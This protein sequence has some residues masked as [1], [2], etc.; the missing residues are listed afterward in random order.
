MSMPQYNGATN[1]DD[2]LVTPW[3]IAG[4]TAQAISQDSVQVTQFIG[5]NAPFP[6][7]LVY[8][9][10]EAPYYDFDQNPLSGFLTFLTSEDFNVTSGGFTYRIPQRY[11]G[12]DNAYYAG[13]RNNRGTGKI[14]IRNGLVS[15]TL[16]ATQN[17][18]IVTDSGLPLTY[19]VVEHFLGGEQYDISISNSASSPV[20]LR[21]LIVPGSIVPF[22]YDPANPLGVAAYT[23]IT[24][25][26]AQGTSL[27]TGIDG[28]SA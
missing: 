18:A 5:Q 22:D 24:P 28:G 15:V 7:N 11:A 16:M 6:T 17:V 4:W 13:G 26:P 23:P 2:P 20:D 12:V 1:A 21:S 19:H 8:V 10:V 3:N 27:L 9:Q 14:Y 25:N